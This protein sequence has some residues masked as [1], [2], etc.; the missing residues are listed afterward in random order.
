MQIRF[1]GTGACLSSLRGKLCI[2]V[3]YFSDRQYT[4]LFDCGEGSY[5]KLRRSRNGK[6]TELMKTLDAIYISHNHGDHLAGI[7]RLLF[8][9]FFR[10]R[11]KPLEIYGPEDVDIEGIYRIF[12]ANFPLKFK[13]NYSKLEPNSQR[14]LHGSLL[15]SIPGKHGVPELAYCLEAD[16]KKVVYTGDTERL[17]LPPHFQNADLLIH[18]ANYTEEEKR[19]TVYKAFNHSS[20]REAGAVASESKARRLALVSTLE[21]HEHILEQLIGEAQLEYNGEIIIP[22][23]LEVM[24]L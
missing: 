21:E 2:E 3:S 23:D 19:G 6:D 17:V 5:D 14:T 12:F 16:G 10:G 20:C 4:V 15:S 11:T 8:G 18:D 7:P 1:I 22:N 9:M 24:T 13:V